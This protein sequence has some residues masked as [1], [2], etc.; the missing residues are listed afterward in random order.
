M[1]VW[2]GA[3]YQVGPGVAALVRHPDA[4]LRRNVRLWMRPQL[5]DSGFPIG[6]W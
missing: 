1:K 5:A 6:G 4:P 3:T 2:G